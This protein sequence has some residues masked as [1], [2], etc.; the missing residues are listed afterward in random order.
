MKVIP[1]LEFPGTT[2]AALA[3]YAQVFGGEMENIMYFGDL[4]PEDQ[5]KGTNPK[6][7]ANAS[8][9]LPGG[10]LLMANDTAHHAGFYGMT[11]M[12]DWDTP[13]AAA[14][15]FA[16]LAQGGSVQMPCGPTF[17]AKA[18][19]VCT[20]QFGVGWMVNCA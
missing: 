1:Y 18:F 14:Q 12:T 17:W 2:A 8:V 6:W 5:I 13:D 9:R 20:D 4:P 19:G 3:F 7:I 10:G 15:A 11:L 16:A